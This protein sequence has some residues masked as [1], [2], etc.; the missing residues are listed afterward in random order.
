M[1]CAT[2][3][4]MNWKRNMRLGAKST[5]I[6]FSTLGSGEGKQTDLC[7]ECKYTLKIQHHNH[8]ATMDWLTGTEIMEQYGSQDVKITVRGIRR[9][10][11]HAARGG[12]DAKGKPGFLEAALKSGI[13]VCED[14]D[15]YRTD[16]LKRMHPDRRE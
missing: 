3:H 14:V 16:I 11:R 5:I 12:P 1:S 8:P 9:C 10:A 15:T 6:E 13:D 2:S 4:G 7:G